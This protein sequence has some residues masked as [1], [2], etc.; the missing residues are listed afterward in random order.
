MNKFFLVTLAFLGFSVTAMAQSNFDPYSVKP[1]FG[2]NCPAKNLDQAQFF[3]DL[4]LNTDIASKAK[5][6]CGWPET[7]PADSAKYELFAHSMVINCYGNPNADKI[8]SALQQFA[9]TQTNN[10]SSQNMQSFK[11]EYYARLKNAN[12]GFRAK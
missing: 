8:E 1:T 7:N 11:G 2:P 5:K 10:C 9:D 4:S 6:K 3:I 12:N